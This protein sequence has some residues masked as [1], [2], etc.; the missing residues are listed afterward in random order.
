[1]AADL[2]LKTFLK[3][4]DLGYFSYDNSNILLGAVGISNLDEKMD[5]AYS[6]KS[7][8]KAGF[9]SDIPN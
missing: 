6:I 7:V 3:A 9:R 4:V 1:M 8:E 2:C 5:E